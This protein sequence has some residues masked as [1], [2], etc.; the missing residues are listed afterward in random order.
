MNPHFIGAPAGLTA[1]ALA[2]FLLSG[3]F[4][5][6]EQARARF[7]IGSPHRSVLEKGTAAPVPG[8]MG[9][10][11][12]AQQAEAAG[13]PV[14]LATLRALIDLNHPVKT[15][16][17]LYRLLKGLPPEKVAALAKEA[18]RLPE[19]DRQRYLLMNPLQ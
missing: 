2:V 10:S 6:F 7:F 9:V 14:S 3:G 8:H 5:G 13:A 12:S 18:M 11:G 1:G 16:V 4:P 19:E 15:D 17:R